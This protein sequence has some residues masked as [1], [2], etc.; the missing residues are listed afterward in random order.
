MIRSVFVGAD[1]VHGVTAT[2]L[3]DWLDRWAPAAEW[4]VAIG[5][6][7]LAMATAYLAKQAKR[8]AAAV[9]DDA[10]AVR[11]SV[12]L[13]REQ[14]LTATAALDAQTAPFLT[15]AAPGD[16]PIDANIREYAG[17]RRDGLILIP[18]WNVGNG[19]AVVDQ[20][21]FIF[22]GGTPLVGTA[23]NPVLPADERTYARFEA[24][25]DTSSGWAEL[26]A[27]FQAN[28]PNFSVLVSY[29]DAGG[30]PRGAVR[31]DMYRGERGWYARQV[32]WGETWEGVRDNPALS[33]HPS[34]WP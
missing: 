34:S 6:I 11:Q 3:Q 12:V 7:L 32:H 15:A 14:N 18:L 1:V 21:I 2:G 30:Q 22:S 33:T 24:S 20:V 28:D 17:D 23:D 16:L 8:E 9:R 25:P 5:T 29:R 4:G 31:L 26:E 27:T 10:D 13:Q 19:L